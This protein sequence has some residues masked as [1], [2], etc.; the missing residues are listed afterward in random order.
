MVEL[1]FLKKLM[2]TKTNKKII[3]N[4]KKYLKAKIKS[5]NG[6]IITNFHGEFTKGKLWIHMLISN[7][8]SD[9]F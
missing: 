7:S 2:L 4:N 1:T 5:H 8:N 6:K 9:C 3:I